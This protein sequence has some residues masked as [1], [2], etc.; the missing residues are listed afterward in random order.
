M[1][2]F[3]EI[4]DFFIA[5]YEHLTILRRYGDL[6]VIQLML[7]LFLGRNLHL[8]PKYPLVEVIL[9]RR[10]LVLPLRRTQ[11]FLL[12]IEGK[13]ARLILILNPLII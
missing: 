8:T 3:A 13:Q 9:L 5:E 12:Q 10:P 6:E 4:M 2:D 11:R 7:R 1:H